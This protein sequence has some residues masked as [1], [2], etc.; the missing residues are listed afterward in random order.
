MVGFTV[1]ASV[2]L[3]TPPAVTLTVPSPGDAAFGTRATMPVLLQLV[4]K[5][6]A[7]LKTTAPVSDPWL[8]PKLEPLIVTGV[9]AVPLL[10][11]ML[12]IFGVGTTVKVTPTLAAEL[13][14]TTTLPVVAV[15]GTVATIVEALQL[16]VAALTPLNVTLPEEP[17]L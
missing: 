7:P 4:T 13:L 9:P 17:K 1:N 10:T 12:E 16:V 15:E 2:L 6:F 3:C 8:E 11:E 5:A 14:V